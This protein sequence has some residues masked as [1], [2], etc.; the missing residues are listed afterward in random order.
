MS[1]PITHEVQAA[2]AL[3]IAHGWTTPLQLGAAAGLKPAATWRRL[4]HRECPRTARQIGHTGRMIALR[5]SPT[6]KAFL[7]RPLQR[8]RKLNAEEVQAG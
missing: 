8:G 5:T 3:L 1:A 4:H 2:V 6:L 7:S